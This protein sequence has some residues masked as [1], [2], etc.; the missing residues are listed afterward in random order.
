LLRGYSAI[1]SNAQTL[2]Y[3]TP[4]QA[5]YLGFS[6]FLSAAMNENAPLQERGVFYIALGLMS[7]GILR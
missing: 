1:A 3:R 2:C 6:D 4:L 7:A 5:L